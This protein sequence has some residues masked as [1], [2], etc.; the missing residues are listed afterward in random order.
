MTSNCDRVREF[1]GAWEARDVEAILARM[2]PD[3]TY[4]NVGLSEARGHEAIRATITPFLITVG[5]VRWSITH[6]AET[7][8][9]VV[10][11]E[12]VDVF[13]MG[14]KTLSIP[15]MGAFEFH[16]DLISAWRD[17]FDLPGFQAQMA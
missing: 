2:T 14:D 12:R 10:L 11:T 7:A 3:A 8:S 1:I 5:A 15:V 9:G 4:L 17:Y 13:V 16:G 6:I